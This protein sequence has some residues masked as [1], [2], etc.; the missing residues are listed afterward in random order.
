MDERDADRRAEMPEDSRKVAGGTSEK[1]ERE[2]QAFTA[3]KGK[4]QPEAEKLLEEVL[5]CENM[6]RALKR[7]RSNKGAPGVDGMT[8]D[9]L[10]P[11]LI[12]EWPCIREELLKETYQ[13]EP[14]KQ[15]EIPKPNGEAASWDSYGLGSDDPTSDP[16]GVNPDF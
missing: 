1:K 12:T 16:S 2:R 11:Y 5:R 14:V 3:A 15:V 8:V 9:E 10:T 13:P 4:T 7:V 6:L